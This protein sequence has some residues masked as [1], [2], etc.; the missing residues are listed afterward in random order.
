MIQKGAKGRNKDL[1]K[2]LLLVSP[3]FL[4][5]F[6]PSGSIHSLSAKPPSMDGIGS[7]GEDDNIVLG[8]HLVG[9]LVKVLQNI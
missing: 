7:G 2:S 5:R 8:Y 6:P 4:K 3:D 1:R 9:L